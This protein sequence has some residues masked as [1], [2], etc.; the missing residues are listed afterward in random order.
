ML[1]LML[2][3]KL[4]SPQMGH[5]RCARNQERGALQPRDGREQTQVRGEPNNIDRREMLEN[6]KII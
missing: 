5:P 6:R 2:P 3:S 1:I 4:S